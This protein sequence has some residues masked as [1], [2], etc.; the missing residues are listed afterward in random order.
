[1]RAVLVFAVGAVGCFFL[2]RVL[3]DMGVFSG[4]RYFPL[5]VFA[6]RAQSIGLFFAAAVVW[7]A[8]LGGIRWLARRHYPLRAVC[9]VGLLLLLGTNFLQGV[10][11]NRRLDRGLAFPVSGKTHAEGIG[12]YDDARAL[13]VTPAN[14]LVHFDRLQP[15]L[16][17]HGRTHPP[18]AVLLFCALIAATGNRPAII[19]LGIAVFSVSLSA[20]ALARLFRVIFPLESGAPIGGEGCAAL[21]F[22]LLPAVQIYYC[23]TLDAVVAALLLAGVALACEKRTALSGLCIWAA[24]FLTFGFVWVV[25]VLAV[26]EGRRKTWP[27]FA[28]TLGI[29]LAAH[30]LLYVGFGF[31]YF[32]A[33]RTASRLENPHG[34]RLFFDPIGYAMTRLE[35]VAEIALFAGP[36]MLWLNGRGAGILRK[37][38]PHAFWLWA[39]AFLSLGGLLVTGAYRTGETARACL[40]VAPFLLLPVFAFFRYSE[41][42]METRREPNK[43]K[44]TLL[45]LVWTQSVL[46][47]VIGDYFW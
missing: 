15:T 8:G 19:G 33:L 20:W 13:V 40:F 44:N 9:A 34:F 41:G 11:P 25:P 39:A 12:Y 4:S 23:A 16:R 38:A 14:F 24:S 30:L 2:A 7:L 18:G 45:I 46:M 1:M 21:L 43:V 3:R 31:N 10:G 35:D 27:R 6:P 37:N 32:A 28:A 22:L 5:N 17:D 29:V 26:V 47:Q 36:F 42:E